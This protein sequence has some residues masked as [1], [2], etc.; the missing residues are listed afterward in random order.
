[1]ILGFSKLEQLDENIGAIDVYQKKWNKD[2]Q[3]RIEALI[4]NAPEP[5]INF[6]EFSILPQRREVAVFGNK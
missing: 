6:R 5:R 3:A 4:K 2:I 1:L